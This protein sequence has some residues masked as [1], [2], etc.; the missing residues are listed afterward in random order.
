[1]RPHSMARRAAAV[2][3]VIV[4]SSITLL[5]GLYSTR[6]PILSAQPR[7]HYRALPPTQSLAACSTAS[8]KP[9]AALASPRNDV[10]VAVA[11]RTMGDHGW[12]HRDRIVGAWKHGGGLDSTRS[13]QRDRFV[14]HVVVS[15]RVFLDGAGPEK[16][17]VRRGTVLYKYMSEA[18]LMRFLGNR[19]VRFSP[20][21]AFNDPFEIRPAIGT[22]E[23]LAAEAHRWNGNESAVST[24]FDLDFPLG[25]RTHLN[26]MIGTTIGIL[27]LTENPC[28]PL[29]WAHY[30]DSHRGAAVGFYV[31]HPFFV[32]SSPGDSLIQYLRMVDYSTQRSTLSPDFFRT[33]QILGDNR[34]GWL[35]LL[36]QKHPVLLTKSPDWAYEKEWRLVRQLVTPGNAEKRWVDRLHYPD[37]FVD[38]Q[39]IA[40]PE[41]AIAS[42]TLGFRSRMQG[43]ADSDGLEEEVIHVL[44][45]T[46]D[47]AHV[48]LW[49]TRP[50]G[51]DFSMVRFSLDD[52]A[53]LREN[54]HPQELVAR[55]QGFTGR[56][57]RKI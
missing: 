40:V 41:E 17:G 53:D 44:A 6:V 23:E 29:M 51:R 54:V 9:A 2:A 38:E 15:K 49:K 14:E 39:I 45:Q 11:R 19:R 42:V 3:C 48:G 31:N 26:Q 34:R 30:A 50:H 5:P 16:N 27:C 13:T 28:Q 35:E 22:V 57:P 24:F 32:D 4:V 12:A 52:E 25:L 37:T 20:A 43:V 55:Q 10:H 33:F 36:E 18:G 56:I 21:L 8:R 46:P 1:M 7:A 47:L